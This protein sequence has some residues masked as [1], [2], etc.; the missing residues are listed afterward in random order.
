VTL[1]AAAWG[2]KAGGANCYQ[3]SKGSSNQFRIK[4]TFVC[5]GRATSVWS[6]PSALP[7]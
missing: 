1:S 5:S 3:V 4:R 7:K 6:R 2:V